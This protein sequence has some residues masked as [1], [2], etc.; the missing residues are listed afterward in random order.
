MFDYVILQFRSVVFRRVFDNCSLICFSVRRVFFK[1]CCQK[2]KFDDVFL[3]SSQI[4]LSLYDVLLKVCCQKL[5]FYDVFAMVMVT[6]CDAC[7]W[8]SLAEPRGTAHA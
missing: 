1:I 8:G 6:I 3:P 2:Y 5:A 4:D 7:A